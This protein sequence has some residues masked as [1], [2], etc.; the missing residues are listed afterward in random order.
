MN[1]SSF[2][3]LLSVKSTAN[4]MNVARTSPSFA[5]SLERQH[6]G[7][8]QHAEPEKRD[9]CRVEPQRRRRRPQ[10]HHADER[11]Q[12]DLFV[13]AERPKRGERLAR[14]RRRVR[15]RRHFRPDDACREAAAAATIA[16][17][18]RHRRGEQPGAEA[19]LDAE[20][21]GRSRR[22]ADWRPSP[23]ATAPTTGSGWRCP[24]TSGSA[25]TPPAAARRRAW[26]RP[27]R[28]ARTPAGRA[29]PSARCC[30]ET[31]ARS[32]RRRGRCCRTGRA[33]T[34]RRGSRPDGRSARRART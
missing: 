21:L 30:S 34:G 19:D 14:R 9:R 11:R 3:W 20:R 32:R 4:Q 24:R 13:A 23:S 6:A 17:E 26:R 27:L 7:R 18:R 15:R 2:S 10:R 16:G 31:P 12:H 25:P 28:R 29:R 33:S 8:E 5:M 22:R 1:P